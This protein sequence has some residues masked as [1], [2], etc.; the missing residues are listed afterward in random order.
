M[1]KTKAGRK[2]TSNHQRGPS[3]PPKAPPPPPPSLVELI[4]NNDKVLEYFQSLQANLDYD[5]D[6]WKGRAKQFE[7]ESLEWKKKFNQLQKKRSRAESSNKRRKDL[8]KAETNTSIPVPLPK[9]S[10]AATP[11]VTAKS[12]VYELN[13][14]SSSSS[15]DEDESLAFMEET[16]PV[17][18]LSIEKR[19]KDAMTNLKLAQTYLD[20]LGI[21]LVLTSTTEPTLESQENHQDEEV[22]GTSLLKRRPDQDIISDIL[23]VIKAMVR[24]RVTSNEF[25][26]YPFMTNQLL[27]CFTDI[28][29]EG[30]D[31]P[32]HPAICGFESMSKALCLMDAY[33]PILESIQVVDREEWYE[34]IEIGMKNRHQM[35]GRFIQSLEGE[36]CQLWPVQDRSTYLV[37]KSLHF[38]DDAETGENDGSISFTSKNLT[39]LSTLCERIFLA[40]L[41]CTSHLYRQDPNS[42]LHF[43]WN[44]LLAT[45]STLN[46]H[47]TTKQAEFPPV[48][49]LC[50]LESMLKCRGYDGS[51]TTLLSF[52]L[53]SNPL[54]SSIISRVLSLVINFTASIHKIRSQSCDDRITDVSNVELKAY[55][56]LGT[57][58]HLLNSDKGSLA[59]REE[60]NQI[61]LLIDDISLDDFVENGGILALLL[62]ILYLFDP[63]ENVDRRYTDLLNHASKSIIPS[64]KDQLLLRAHAKAKAQFEVR[65]IH[66]NFRPWE[67][68][69]KL[70]KVLNKYSS[71]EDGTELLE[72]ALSTLSTCHELADG[73]TAILTLRWLLS[74]LSTKDMTSEKGST[75]K[76]LNQ[77]ERIGRSISIRVINLER[78]QDRLNVFV[79]Q[80]IHQGL[81]AIRAVS[82]FNHS[83]DPDENFVEC[84][85][86]NFNYAF[87]GGGKPAQVEQH[88]SKLVGPPFGNLSK[89]VESHWRPNDLKPFDSE[90]PDVLTLAR[91]S[92]SEKACALSHIASWIGVK[93]S[94]SMRQIL[95][96]DGNNS[97]IRCPSELYQSFLISGYARGPALFPENEGM[98][99][100]PICVILEDDAIL[101]DRFVDRLEALLEEL[102]RDFHFCSLGYS[103]PKTAPLIPYSSQISIPTS[104]WYL[105]GYILSLDGAKYLLDNLPIRGPV[106]SWIG[107]KMF[108]NWDNMFGHAMG[109]GMAT[110]PCVEPSISRKDLRSLLKFRAFAAQIPLCSQ[111]YGQQ[112]NGSFSA[113]TGRTWTQRDTDIRYSGNSV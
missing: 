9:R 85:F 20:Q 106:D 108:S 57:E 68:S 55:E 109:V 14:E 23:R 50:V 41:V 74:Y 45:T 27:P 102:P 63:I 67:Y 21:S 39:R 49:S 51:T 30:L 73:E 69:V 34:R 37:S 38:H 4:Q 90:A 48:Q 113:S 5:V 44:Y 64:T 96:E 3:S 32:P 94:L 33:C 97:I 47:S 25:T 53:S 92:P 77:I 46:I 70:W 95:K 100:T 101:V 16:A 22:P 84:V 75:T 36:I 17:N 31:N 88:L 18:E 71:D 83:N 99:A 19:Q 15:G 11:P 35:V 7:A 72:L 52:M 80:A 103:R 6:K 10:K 78:R 54:L 91:I 105:T 104:I 110:R 76:T 87:D 60:A 82:S 62:G 26:Y 111:K 66:S 93:D 12:K 79:A 28:Q 13:L 56:R 89:L 40:K 58:F 8:E 1:P 112:Q 59:Y 29:D 42:A 43:V 86:D 107:L 2:K 24:L 65:Q 81:M 98:K 61:R